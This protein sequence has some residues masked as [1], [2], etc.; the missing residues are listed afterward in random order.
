MCYNWVMD[1]EEYDKESRRLV[2][3]RD[4][5]RCVV[6]GHQAHDIHE[7]IPRSALPGKQNANILF[8]EK[9]R[10]CL[11]RKCHASVHTVWG[12]TMLLGIMMLKYGYRY[13][14]LPFSKYFK[15]RL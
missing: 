6:C 10:C 1:A 11:C 7:I 9:N 3:Q 2:V 12:R 14:E 4:R 15:A 8:S 5:W 13:P